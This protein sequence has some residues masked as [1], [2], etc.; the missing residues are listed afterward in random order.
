MCVH[1]I[2][3]K[4]DEDGDVM[5]KIC[6]VAATK[7]VLISHSHHLNDM[8]SIV[9]GKVKEI[10][11]RLQDFTAQGS[12]W[13]LSEFVFA[14]LTFTTLGD[15]RGG[16]SFKYPTRR[17]LLNIESDDNLC[18]VYCVIAHFHQKSIALGLR[19]KGSSYQSYLKTM[20]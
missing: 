18:L 9:R 12:N 4:M 13:V 2:F 16:C 17:G 7:K 14:D 20:I 11:E 6:F 5:D 8:K 1:A 19:K 15:M 10:D 3:L